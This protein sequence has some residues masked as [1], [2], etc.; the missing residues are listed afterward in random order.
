MDMALS[1]LA[2][3]LAMSFAKVNAA[4]GSCFGSA[5]GF[6]GMIIVWPDETGLISN[7]ARAALFS[8]TGRV[9]IS[10]SAMRRKIL[11]F[12]FTGRFSRCC[13]SIDSKASGES[14]SICCCASLRF[15]SGRCLTCCANCALSSW[16]CSGVKG[17]LKIRIKGLKRFRFYAAN[18]TKGNLVFVDS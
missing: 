11:L 15:S 4:V 2:S 10:L 14:R 9:S 3:F 7:T 12:D 18:C 1:F 8:A 17:M 5:I 6:L 16:T 13:S